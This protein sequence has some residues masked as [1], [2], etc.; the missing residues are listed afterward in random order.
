MTVEITADLTRACTSLCVYPSS[1]PI[2]SLIV[3]SDG[4][5]QWID[6]APGAVVWGGGTNTALDASYIAEMWRLVIG[7]QS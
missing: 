1:T 4:T 3:W 7:W 5:I 2:E 6:E